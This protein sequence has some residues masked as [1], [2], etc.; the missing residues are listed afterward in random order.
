[1]KMNPPNLPDAARALLCQS[2]A[3]LE[4]PDS[5]IELRNL[6]RDLVDA[7]LRHLQDERAVTDVLSAIRR[8]IDRRDA[9][10]TEL[11]YDLPRDLDG[12]RDASAPGIVLLANHALAT[13][14]LEPLITIVH[15]AL[16]RGMPVPAR[17]IV[18]LLEAESGPDPRDEVAQ[19]LGEWLER[20]GSDPAA[21][22][23]VLGRRPL[24]HAKL[25]CPE[26]IPF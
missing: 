12:G 23:E 15:G 16:S 21:V 22:A 7:A 19:I 1:M 4:D 6:A 14:A 25:Y 8:A 24:V 26:E 2:I 5:S 3:W 9:L 20:K 18:A 17:W 13:S 10:T 11:V